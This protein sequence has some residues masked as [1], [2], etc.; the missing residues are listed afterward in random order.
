MNTS[1]HISFPSE[2]CVM[3]LLVVKLHVLNILGELD[4]YHGC[5]CLGSLSCQSTKMHGTD[6]VSKASV[7]KLVHVFRLGR[8]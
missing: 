3:Q 2:Q 6:T 1:E 5:W 4:Q 7:D 8:I